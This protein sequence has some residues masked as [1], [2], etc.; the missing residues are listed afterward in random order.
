MWCRL[1]QKGD[2]PDELV[3]SVGISMRT[4]AVYGSANLGSQIGKF[5]LTDANAE[6]LSDRNVDRV[7]DP[8]FCDGSC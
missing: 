8:D 4:T 6:G 2:Q 3:A 1:W 7:P 5:S